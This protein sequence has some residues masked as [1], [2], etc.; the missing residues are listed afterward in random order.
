[1]SDLQPTVNLSLVTPE[2]IV[3]ADKVEM[4]VIPGEEGEMGVLPAHISMVTLLKKGIVMVYQNGQVIKKFFV[5]GGCSEINE[6]EC[7]VLAEAAED[8]TTLT[9]AELT[10]KINK[11]SYSITN[12]KIADKE[13]P[14][15]QKELAFAKAMFEF[16]SL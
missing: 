4:V 13:V 11:L 15:T 3:F 16:V 7:I 5:T 2:K 14:V 8:I 12:H 9:K 6:T 1:M 10:V